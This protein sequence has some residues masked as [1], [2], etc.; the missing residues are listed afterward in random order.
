MSLRKITLLSSALAL[1]AAHGC[2]GRVTRGDSE[3]HFLRCTE[4]SKCRVLGSAFSCVDGFCREGNGLDA[5]GARSSSRGPAP[6]FSAMPSF[7]DAGVDGASPLASSCTHATYPARPPA[8]TGGDS[9]FFIVQRDVDL[10]DS[11]PSS[12]SQ[13]TR[14]RNIGFDLDN[15]C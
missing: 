15:L 4:D 1:V 3:S 13:P 14:Y 8:G 12:A 11:P 5:G 10:G 2:S 7:A 6:G 9:E